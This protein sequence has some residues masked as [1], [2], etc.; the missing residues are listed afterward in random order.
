MTGEALIATRL[1][2]DGPREFEIVPTNIYRLLSAPEVT[3]IQLVANYAPKFVHDVGRYPNRDILE[4]LEQ[5][6]TPKQI[7][8]VLRNIHRF[9][10]D[11]APEE[12]PAF[13][14]CDP[15]ITP[16]GV[17]EGVRDGDIDAIEIWKAA[18]GRSRADLM[19]GHYEYDSKAGRYVPRRRKDPQ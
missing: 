1:H 16:A 4:P 12:L 13:S 15:I 11:I 3:Y 14:H 10:D 5:T 19:P 17:L 7:N 2:D 18:G 6:L 9:L 8:Q